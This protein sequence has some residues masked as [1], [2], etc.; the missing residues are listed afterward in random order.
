MS[1]L[2]HVTQLLLCIALGGCGAASPHEEGADAHLSTAVA[3]ERAA[4][5]QERPRMAATLDWRRCV[6]QGRGL[7]CSS[8]FRDSTAERE[9]EAERHRAFAAAHRSASQAL[10]DAEASACKGLS[11]DDLDIPLLARSHYIVS[12]EPIYRG[13]SSGEATA[14]HL[15][16]A[17]VTFSATTGLTLERLRRLLDC[18]VARAAALGHDNAGVQFDPLAV[19]GATAIASSARDE[20]SV[21]ITVGDPEA[22]SKILER[23]RAL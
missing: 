4:A 5:E 1:G 17:S 16:G 2:D 13:P 10:R 22:A 12:V 18:E 7:L 8:M 3:H 23:A 11:G 9:R 19:P 15:L 6:A 21:A 14:K 20:L